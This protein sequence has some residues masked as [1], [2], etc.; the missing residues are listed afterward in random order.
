M[1]SSPASTSRIASLLWLEDCGDWG[2]I[3]GCGRCGVSLGPWLDE[4][5]LLDH[6]GDHWRA[7]HGTRGGIVPDVVWL[8][9]ATCTA[10]GCTRPRHTSA[11]LCRACHAR[12]YRATLKAAA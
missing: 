1:A 8:E 2:T 10:P 7:E 6:L 9:D 4:A 3:G 12:A 5:Q 11:G